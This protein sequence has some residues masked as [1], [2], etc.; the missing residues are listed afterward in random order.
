MAGKER[1]TVLILMRLP[2][3][4]ERRASRKRQRTPASFSTLT[5]LVLPIFV[6]VRGKALPTVKTFQAGIEKGEEREEREE[7]N[8][9]KTVEKAKE[10]TRE[11]RCVRIEVVGSSVGSLISASVRQLLPVNRK[12]SILAINLYIRALP[13]LI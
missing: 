6:L 7:R 12:Y 11:G 4:L 2:V 9:I 3:S 13:I 8:R 5:S 1:F 10:E